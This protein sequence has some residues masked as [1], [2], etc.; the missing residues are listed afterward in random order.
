[1]LRTDSVSPSQEGQLDS[2][3]SHNLL[4]STCPDRPVVSSNAFHAADTHQEKGKAINH[5]YFDTKGS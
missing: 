3:L 5:P 4:P 1:M 2:F